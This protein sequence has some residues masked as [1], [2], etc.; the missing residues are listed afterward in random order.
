MLAEWPD[1]MHAPQ[2]LLPWTVEYP[3]IRLFEI[4][5]VLKYTDFF[6]ARFFSGDKLNKQWSWVTLPMLGHVYDWCD[7][8]ISMQISPCWI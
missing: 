5:G 7:A 6:H 3:L 4:S 1:D 2:K 8:N